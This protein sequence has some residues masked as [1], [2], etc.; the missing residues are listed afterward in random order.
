MGD[1]DVGD[2]EVGENDGAVGAG[3]VGDCEV[4][5]NDVGLDDGGVG[6][7]GLPVADGTQRNSDGSRFSQAS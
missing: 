5:E 4:G 7:V 2:C 3:D 6:G 1:S